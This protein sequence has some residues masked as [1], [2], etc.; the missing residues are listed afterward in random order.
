MLTGDL[1][2]PC[3]ATTLPSITPTLTLQPVPQKR[4]GALSHFILVA[5]LVVIKFEACAGTDT[6]ATAAAAATAFAFIN[7]RRFISPR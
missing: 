3:V 2:S 6:P 5:S 1:M 7:S 4:Q